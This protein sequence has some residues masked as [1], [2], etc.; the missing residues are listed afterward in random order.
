MVTCS[1]RIFLFFRFVARCNTIAD[2]GKIANNRLCVRRRTSSCQCRSTKHNRHRG[3]NGIL[4]SCHIS[5]TLAIT[6]ESD[7]LLPCFSSNKKKPS[8]FEAALM[9]IFGGLFQIRTGV[10]GFADRCLTSRP[11]DLVFLRVQRYDFFAD[12][13]SFERAFCQFIFPNADYQP[14]RTP[15]GQK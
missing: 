2:M 10:N 8:S 5:H 3:S 4:C 7:T 14:I 1:R 11:R 13:Q 9:R 6:S 15:F 12:W